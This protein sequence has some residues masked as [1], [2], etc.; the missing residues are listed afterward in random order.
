MVGY[1]NYAEFNIDKGG[2]L[3][4]QTSHVNDDYLKLFT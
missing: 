4:Q 2:L 3:N 1:H